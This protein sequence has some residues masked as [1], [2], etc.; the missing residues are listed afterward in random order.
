VR[1]ILRK[2]NVFYFS[3]YSFSEKKLAF[4]PDAF[5]ALQELERFSI[6][7]ANARGTGKSM[8]LEKKFDYTHD[9]KTALEIDGY[10]PGD[11]HITLVDYDERMFWSYGLG[12]GNNAMWMGA[13]LEV[14]WPGWRIFVPQ[15][16]SSTDF[17]KFLGHE[18]PHFYPPFSANFDVFKTQDIFTQCQTITDKHP[19]NLLCILADEGPRFTRLT[20]LGLEALLA[21]GPQAITDI[22]LREMTG[23]ALL[24]HNVRGVLDRQQN[25]FWVD[26]LGYSKH[27]NISPDT[28]LWKGWTIVPS[29]TVLASG[30]GMHLNL[31]PHPTAIKDYSL[32]NL[33]RLISA[34]EF[35]SYDEDGD[36]ER[37]VS[38]NTPVKINAP[39]LLDDAVP[40]KFIM[41]SEDHT[42]EGPRIMFE[43]KGQEVAVD[44]ND[45]SSEEWDWVRNQNT[46][47]KKQACIAA[48]EE[49]VEIFS[50]RYTPELWLQDRRPPNTSYSSRCSYTDEYDKAA[51]DFVCKPAPLLSKQ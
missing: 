39:Q 7:D 28:A 8:E 13:W 17:L 46:E 22:Y 33:S 30:A 42:F 14:F 26:E 15:H 6:H 41:K 27:F 35:D 48:L 36:F 43:Y 37:L 4:G 1:L 19:S 16:E 49:M 51:Y 12:T 45:E 20:E 38:M 2:H 11:D 3:H 5:W 32:A 50:D 44:P 18:A 9:L 24:K 40:E 10:N 29:M 23:D 47:L 25:I 21:T 31:A 34:F